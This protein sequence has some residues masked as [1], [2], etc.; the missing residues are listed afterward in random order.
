MA[1]GAGLLAVVAFTAAAIPASR[2]ARLQPLD[3]LREE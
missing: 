2:A 1:A 3:A